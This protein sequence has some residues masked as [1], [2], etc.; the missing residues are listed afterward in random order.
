MSNIEA[1]FFDDNKMDKKLL[2]VKIK[3]P[4]VVKIST[5][6]KEIVKVENKSLEALIDIPILDDDRE[7]TVKVPKQ[8]AVSTKE[9]L[10]KMPKV[11]KKLHF[12][13]TESSNITAYKDVEERF[14]RSHDTDDSLFLA[15][16][17]YKK[18]NYKKAE[19]WALQTN[20]ENENIEESIFI[21]IKSKA[22]LGEKNEAIS[23]L[24][25]YI[26]KSNSKKA[27]DVLDTIKSNQY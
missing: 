22:K 3:Q 12:E 4:E 23:I 18:E 6:E 14:Y 27:Q 20:K 9:V 25:T 7:E 26:K 10:N 11:Y 2:T 13:I 21:F 1:Y 15:K 8:V 17:Y 19:Y 5:L 24:N 16:S